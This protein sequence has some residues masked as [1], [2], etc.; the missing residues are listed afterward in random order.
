MIVK[1]DQMSQ[2]KGI[3]LTNSIDE[4]RVGKGEK[5]VVQ[6]Y[7]RE[8]YLIDGLKFDI[9]LYVLVTSA[10]PP[11]RIYLYHDGLVRFATQKYSAKMNN[12]NMQNLFIHLTNY[13]VNKG[14]PDF[15][16]AKDLGA[17]FGHK[18]SWQT[19]L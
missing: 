17:D 13:S 19:I 8:P 18:R 4:I 5:Y 7:L 6:E 3:Y 9:R 2:G 1:P 10:E 16:A 11:M 14:N 12:A 15:V